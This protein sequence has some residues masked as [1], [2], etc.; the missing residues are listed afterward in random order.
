MSIEELKKDIL[1]KEIHLKERSDKLEGKIEIADTYIRISNKRKF[2]GYSE[3]LEKWVYGSPIELNG[4]HYILSQRL[5]EGLKWDL[6]IPKT[7]G[8]LTGLQDI[9]GKEI[10]EG[11]VV[12]FYEEGGT[13]SITE[14]V[15]W[16]KSGY[17]KPFRDP[18]Y[19][20][21]EQGA[22]FCDKRGFKVSGNIHNER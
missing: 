12:E 9:D 6:V 5:G 20:D 17:Y 2:R 13:E 3:K 8:Q 1:F 14:V 7:V 18:Y 22:G 15:E 16:D 10:Y 11:D 19:V 4:K 21:D